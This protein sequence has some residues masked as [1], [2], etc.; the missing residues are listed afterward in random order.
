LH[1]FTLGILVPIGLA[2]PADHGLR[3]GTKTFAARAIQVVGISVDDEVAGV[4]E[5][6][7][8]HGAR[9]PASASSRLL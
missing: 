2:C 5:L 9:F 3:R 8:A 1:A 7:E 4:R 6:G